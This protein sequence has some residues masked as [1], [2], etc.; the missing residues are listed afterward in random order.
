MICND[1]SSTFKITL[2]LILTFKSCYFFLYFIS[3]INGFF[4][5]ILRCNVC[6]ENKHN[7][8]YKFSFID[9][10]FLIPNDMLHSYNVNNYMN[11]L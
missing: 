4:V 6:G 3:K 10:I 5:N 9:E 11:L 2:F 1:K 8:N 7:Y